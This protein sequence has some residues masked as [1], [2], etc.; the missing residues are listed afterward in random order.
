MSG[1]ADGDEDGFLQEVSEQITN[2]RGI[3]PLGLSMLCAADASGP[4][5]ADSIYRITKADLEAIQENSETLKRVMQTA[6]R[7]LRN[8]EYAM[9]LASRSLTAHDRLAAMLGA[10][11]AGSVVAYTQ[12]KK[13]VFVPF[14]VLFLYGEQF[15]TVEM[16]LEALSPELSNLLSKKG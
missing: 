7:G 11:N 12:N 4:V 2:I 8:D 1:N 6:L 13:T 14:V 16:L 5:L 3:S 10:M 15:A 9:R